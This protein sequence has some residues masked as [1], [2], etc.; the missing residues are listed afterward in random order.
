MSC[1]DSR[2]QAVVPN[3]GAATS[4][5]NHLC[6]EP[7]LNTPPPSSLRVF[8][9]AAI[10]A[11]PQI[12]RS[13]RRDPSPTPPPSA[14]PPLPVH[15]SICPAKNPQTSFHATVAANHTQAHAAVSFNRRPARNPIRRIDLSP[16]SH[17][18][19]R[20]SQPRAPCVD[21]T[22]RPRSAPP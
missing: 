17:S 16:S 20:S 5:L 22:K 18:A 4:L 6:P 3:Y 19:H 15:F 8:S 9:A 1:S 2:F 7:L 10:N 14:Q 11:Q 21:S 13:D 12:H